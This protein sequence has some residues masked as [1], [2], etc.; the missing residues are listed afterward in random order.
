MTK[1]VNNLVY[2]HTLACTRCTTRWP[3][4]P[5]GDFH[6]SSQARACSFPRSP[7][8]VILITALT[9]NS[10][11]IINSVMTTETHHAHSI[12]GFEEPYVA[13]ERA[14][15]QKHTADDLTALETLVLRRVVAGGCLEQHT[16]RSEIGPSLS[17]VVSH[18]VERNLVR[19]TI[20][21]RDRR[22]HVLY[23]TGPG[24]RL[25]AKLD[26]AHAANLNNPI[27]VQQAAPAPSSSQHASSETVPTMSSDQSEAK[28]TT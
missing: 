16:L 2:D 5:Q 3:E 20:D 6:R 1:L 4:R 9:F 15:R 12:A 7:G 26:A 14:R 22:R 28:P 11:L 18:L 19:P 23:P 8:P 13:Y 17:R 24:Q 27:H 21:S 25:L 10:V